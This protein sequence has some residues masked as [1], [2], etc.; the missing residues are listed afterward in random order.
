MTFLELFNRLKSEA[1]VSGAALTTLQ[2]VTKENLRLKNWIAQSYVEIQ[3]D[4]LD[5][6]WMRKEITFNTVADQQAYEVG[7]AKDINV[8]DFGIWK[9]D[10]FRGFLSSA[11]VGNEILLPQF[12]DYATFRDSYIYNS[13]REVKGRPLYSTIRPED[14]ALL[15][16]PIPNDVYVI[17]AVYYST[18]DELV[19]DSNTPDFP[20]RFHML[21]VYRA[22]EKYGF[23]EVAPE[24]IEA[25]REYGGKIFSK[26]VFDQTD[27]VQV[28]SSLI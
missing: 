17:P 20:D 24:Q 4:R 25:G 22:M 1:G 21:V 13:Q 10:S 14:K 23:F 19:A 5:W 12:L 3:L 7:P 6:Q 15:F 18:V 27:I 11:G 8:S 26:L 28:G 9:N 2:G 16:W